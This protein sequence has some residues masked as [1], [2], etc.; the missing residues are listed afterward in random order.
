MTSDGTTLLGADDKAGISMIMTLLKHFKIAPEMPSVCVCFT[1]DEEI[2]N[3]VGH[4]RL[5]KL[6]SGIKNSFGVT[7]DGGRAPKLVFETFSAY[8]FDVTVTGHNI[9]PGYAFGKMINSIK[10]AADLTT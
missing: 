1:P 6:T 9:H 10:Y 4:I 2:G 5:E 8:C 7:L 3:G